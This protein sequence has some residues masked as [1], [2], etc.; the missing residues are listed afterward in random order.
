MFG[1]FLRALGLV[2]ASKVYSGSCSW[3]LEH[4]RTGST[5]E[6][7]VELI[8]S[9]ATKPMEKVQGREEGMAWQGWY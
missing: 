6:V 9:G 4:S 8:V 7:P 3:N 5:R 2:C 1:S